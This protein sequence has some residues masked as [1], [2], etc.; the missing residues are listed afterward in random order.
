MMCKILATALVVSHNIVC[1]L[2]V[3]PMR[4]AKKLITKINLS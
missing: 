4:T 3:C 2:S 1:E